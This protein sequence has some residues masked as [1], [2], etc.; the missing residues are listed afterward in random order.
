MNERPDCGGLIKQIS[1]EMRKK[2]NNAIRSYNITLA[3]LGALIELER[4]P[5]GQRSLKELEKLLHVAQSTAAGII[6]RLEQKGFVQG[7]EATDDRRVKLVRITP[8]GQAC[9][10]NSLQKRN[11]AEEELLGG[12]TEAEQKQ[13]YILLKKVR[14]SI[15]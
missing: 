15:G 8:D 10:H 3:Q 14:D 13:F 5:D 1:D 12:L 6:A 11:V 7:F 4:A 9:V 2:A